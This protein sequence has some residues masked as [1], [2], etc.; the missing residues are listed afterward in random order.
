MRRAKQRDGVYQRKDRPGWWVSYIDADG[1]R[2]RRKVVASTRQQACDA[3]RRFK[4][5]EER[6]KAL[7]VRPDADITTK[8]L[9]DRFK[10]YQKTRVA[11]STF[12]RLDGILETLEAHLPALA[13]D[14]TRGKVNEYVDTRALKVRPGTVQKELFT[15]SKILRLAVDEWGLLNRNAAHGVKPPKQSEGRT[16]YLTPGELKAALEAA[17]P[18]MRAP[19][20]LAACTGCRR[21]ELLKLRW[22]DV[23]LD[24]RLLTLR[25]TKNN[26]TRILRIGD[27]AVQVFASLPHGEASSLVFAGVDD[28]KLS[29]YCR[30]VFHKLGITDAS[31]HTLRHTMAS[32]RVMQGEDL[33]L[34]GQILGHKTLRMTA[35]YAHLSP[36][37]MAKAA[38]TLDGIMCGVLGEGQEATRMLGA[39]TPAALKIPQKLA[40]VR[41]PRV[42]VKSMPRINHI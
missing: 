11:A 38:G 41:H 6:A 18:W 14:I 4:T 21:G 16:K 8:A 26:T 35:R 33:Y 42:T 39:G 22:M 15:L 20:A 17:E 7:G 28:Q 32:W 1:E 3:L 23:D 24:R 30:R 27:A 12:E 19:M 31:F 29:V 10:K 25:E 5:G 34:V 40:S 2:V 36:E 37:Y 13:K 9:I